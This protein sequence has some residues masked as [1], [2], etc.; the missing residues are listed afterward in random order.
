[1]VANLVISST[2]LPGPLNITLVNGLRLFTINGGVQVG[3][4]NPERPR[5]RGV[6]VDSASGNRDVQAGAEAMIELA[7][8][9]AGAAASSMQ[10]TVSGKPATIISAEGGQLRFRVPADLTPGPALLTLTVNG[11]AAPGLLMSIDLKPPVV[12]SVSVSGGKIDAQRPARGGELLTVMIGRAEAGLT[13]SQL[14]VVVNGIVHTAVQVTPGET[15]GS[16]RVDF[17][18]DTAAGKGA[19]PL[20]VKIDSRQSAPYTLPV[21]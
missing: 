13:A 19:L 16:Y 7:G 8:S 18:L 4:Y 15:E 11:E 6:V 5:L 14:K 2:A 9:A 3:A 1:M 12:Q 17:V 10:L 20:V 21:Q